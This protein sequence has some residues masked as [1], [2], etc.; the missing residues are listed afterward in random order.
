M[1]RAILE[2]ARTIKPET[3]AAIPRVTKASAPHRMSEDTK[4][5]LLK[6]SATYKAIE[7]HERGDL[8]RVAREHDVSIAQLH[9]EVNR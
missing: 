8:S 1:T 3:L 2:F 6:A 7:F 9:R 4:T 5:R